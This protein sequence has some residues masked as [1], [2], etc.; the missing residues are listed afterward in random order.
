MKKI[1]M[2]LN[3]LLSAI[4]GVIHFILSFTEY[5]CCLCSGIILFFVIALGMFYLT[6][7]IIVNN[8]YAYILPLI[9]LV[10][11]LLCVCGYTFLGIMSLFSI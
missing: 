3:M 10:P 8:L 1:F 7:E 4:F 9:I 2:L 6:Y 11:T 5:L